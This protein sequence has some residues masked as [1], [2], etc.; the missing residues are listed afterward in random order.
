MY[1]DLPLQG[2][3]NEERHLRY[4]AKK[5]INLYTIFNKSG[6]KPFAITNSPGTHLRIS[7]ESGIEIRRIF[8]FK[9]NMYVIASE[10]VYEIDSNEIAVLLG[11]IDTASGY[12][13]MASNKDQLII[14]DGVKG[15]IIE[16]SVLSEITD[17]NFLSNPTD[18]A[19]QDTFFIVTS[20]ANNQ[21]AISAS[22]DGTVWPALNYID[23]ITHATDKLIAVRSFQGLLY[24]FGTNTTQVW[25]NAGRPDFPFREQTNMVIEYGAYSPAAIVVGHD[26]L[27]WLGGTRY[28]VGP[29]IMT[30]GTRPIPVSKPPVDYQIQ[31]YENITDAQAYIYQENGHLFYIL[32][33]TAA[34]HTWVYDITMQEWSEREMIDGSRHI[35]QDHVFFN[36]RHYIGSYKEAKLY[37]SSIDFYDDDGEDIRR[38]KICQHIA[39]E[40]YHNIVVNS[41][42]L[43]LIGGKVPANN[44]NS[45]PKL[46]ISASKDGGNT[47]GNIREV[48]LGKIGQRT[49]RTAIR[50]WGYGH[51][52]TF[53]I[54]FFCQ[55]PFQ[56]LGILLDISVMGI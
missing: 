28:G 40:H 6:K 47:Y 51:M 25:Y 1:I 26:L 53:K 27:V 15:Y 20:T 42:E 37:Q 31:S 8:E 5:L 18:V 43:D 55:V 11:T 14:V 2:G 9:G 35:G 38:T 12:V 36:R 44:L 16:S 34:N 56:I 22:N 24:F 39:D 54:E 48:E 30:D 29:V 4:N 41:I 19:S 3:Y 7:L 33:F 45:A 32:N 17:P 13:G 21:W 52:F 46:Y 23:F 10:Y 50:R 49:T